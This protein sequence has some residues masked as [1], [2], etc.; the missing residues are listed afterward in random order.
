MGQIK[1]ISIENN[2]HDVVHIKTE[3][4]H[5]VSF[6][7]GQ[8]VD[9]SVNK[10]G[11]EEELRPFT[12]TSLPSDNHLEF[13][14]KT[15]PEHNGVTEQIGKLKQG[16]SLSI[17]EVFGDIQYKGEGIFIAGGAGITPFIS[18]FKS[19]EKQHSLGKNKLIFANKT[20]NDIINQVFFNRLLGENF[21][22]VL[23]EEEVAGF[24][25]GYIT[26]ELIKGKIESSDAYF[27]LCGPPPMMDT[28][29]KSL[30][31]LGIND[32]HIIKEQF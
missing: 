21:I 19:L 10:P 2:T 12:F 20:S 5:D 6:L 27:Y 23:S 32:T 13:F 16:D 29:L 14:I 3:K 31:D 28:V 9:V 17:G 15:Y 1:I 18:I 7:P 8:A 30:Q 26:K 25:H 24:E 22:N 11:F 4:P